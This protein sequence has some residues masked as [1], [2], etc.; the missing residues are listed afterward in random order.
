MCI[1][2]VD[3]QQEKLTL[4]EARRNFAEMRE[5]MDAEH[6]SEVDNMLWPE[7][8]RLPYV[9]EDWQQMDFFDILQYPSPY[10]IYDIDDD[11]LICTD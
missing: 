5:T 2:C 9:D 6:I 10:D 7:E 8:D 1:I 11:D 3:F 4:K